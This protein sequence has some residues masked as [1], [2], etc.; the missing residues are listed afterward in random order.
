MKLFYH[1][2]SHYKWNFNWH[3]DLRWF[4]T[5]L[6]VLLALNR[7]KLRRITFCFEAAWHSRCMNLPKLL[8]FKFIRILQHDDFVIARSWTQFFWYSFKNLWS[9][10]LGFKIRVKSLA[11]A[12]WWHLWI[13]HSPSLVK[14]W[15]L[16]FLIV[17]YNPNTT[18]I[19]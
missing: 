3:W 13:I 15:L 2:P 5:I 12:R 4:E 6:F 16:F 1:P 18:F 17:N 19:T 8:H 14:R 11:M 9:R 7:L 10:W